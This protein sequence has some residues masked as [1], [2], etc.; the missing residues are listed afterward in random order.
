MALYMV[1]FTYTTEASAAMAKNSQDRSIPVRE[2]VERLGGRFIGMYYCF[3]E[4]DGVVLAELPDDS[5]ALALAM[6]AISPGHCF[7]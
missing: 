4:F 3:G 1:Q 7:Q 6:A 2:V 5:T